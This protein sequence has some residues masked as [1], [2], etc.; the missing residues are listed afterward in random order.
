MNIINWNFYCA[1]LSLVCMGD[2][3]PTKKCKLTIFSILKDL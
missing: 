2:K 3:M 1:A